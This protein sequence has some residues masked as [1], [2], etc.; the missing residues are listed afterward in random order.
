MRRNLC[1]QQPRFEGPSKRERGTKKT[2][3]FA[4]VERLGGFRRRVVPDASGRTLKDANR[5]VVDKQAR[6]RHSPHRVHRLVLGFGRSDF[7]E[8]AQIGLQDDPRAQV[9]EWGKG[10]PVNNMVDD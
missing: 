5:E 7:A 3:V 6:L 8:K 2:P 4:A 9:A 1:G 10:P